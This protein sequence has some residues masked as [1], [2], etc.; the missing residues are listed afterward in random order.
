MVSSR[1][2]IASFPDVVIILNDFFWHDIRSFSILYN[3][4]FEQK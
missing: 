2:H 4:D 3:N 1:K